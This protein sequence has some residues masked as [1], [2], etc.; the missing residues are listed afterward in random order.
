MEKATVSSKAIATK[1]R[2][3]FADVLTIL[4]GIAVVMLH[5]SL[6]VFSL[7]H[8]G[9]LFSSASCVYLRG[10]HLFYAEWHEFAW[11]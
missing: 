10:T 6:N 2:F 9:L 11:V 1:K 3:V 5:T 8:L 4:A 7:A